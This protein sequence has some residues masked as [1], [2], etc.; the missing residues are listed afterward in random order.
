MSGKRK[1]VI[2][3][4]TRSSGEDRY[5]LLHS[6]TGEPLFYHRFKKEEVEEVRMLHMAGNASELLGVFPEQIRMPKELDQESGECKV[7]VTVVPLED[8]ET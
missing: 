4:E 7:H 5:K 3:D 1:R 2:E 6:L 8:E